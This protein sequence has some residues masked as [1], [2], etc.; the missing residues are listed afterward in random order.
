[1]WAALPKDDHTWAEPWISQL[2]DLAHANFVTVSEET[3]LKFKQFSE[4]ET[5]RLIVAHRHQNDDT[6]WYDDCIPK[7]AA[8][9]Q[10]SSVLRVHFVDETVQ[11]FF[12]RLLRSS[13]VMITE[14]MDKL[15]RSVSKAV[16]GHANPYTRTA[17]NYFLEPLVNTIQEW[18]GQSSCHLW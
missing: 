18:K 6:K 3:K 4:D 11:H 2:Q 12:A 1:L 13:H 8:Q 9:V 15:K 14:E 5:R 7:A 16:Y 10:A 17:V